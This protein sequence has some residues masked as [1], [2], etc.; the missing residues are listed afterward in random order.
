MKHD[1]LNYDKKLALIVLATLA[2]LIFIA[3]ALLALSIWT[4]V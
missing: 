3:T 1:I 2:S 4:G